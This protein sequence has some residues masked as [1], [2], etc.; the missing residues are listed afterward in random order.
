LYFRDF[1]GLKAWFQTGALNLFW[2]GKGLVGGYLDP[3]VKK[4]IGK[5]E[6]TKVTLQS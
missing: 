4:N 1:S 2:P 6:I 3:A 5:I